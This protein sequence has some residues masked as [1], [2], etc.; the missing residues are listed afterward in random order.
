MQKNISKKLFYILT[1]GVFCIAIDGMNHSSRAQE[2]PQCN[3]LMSTCMTTL[4]WCHVYYSLSDMAYDKCARTHDRTYK[5][6]KT[7]PAGR[8]PGCLAGCQFVSGH[9]HCNGPCQ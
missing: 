6:P 7:R 8:T 3:D 2:K 5:N 4:K 1:I 9:Q